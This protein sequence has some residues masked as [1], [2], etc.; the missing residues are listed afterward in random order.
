MDARSCESL[1][2]LKSNWWTTGRFSLVLA[3]LIA[4]AFP[5]VLLGLKT[6]VFRD[7]M[8]FGYS[9][10]HY[11]RESFWAG[12]IPLWNPLSQCGLPFLAQWNTMVLYPLSFIYLLLPCRVAQLLLPGHLFLGGWGCTCW[13]DAGPSR[14]GIGGVG[15]AFAFNG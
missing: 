9:I 1:S 3:L 8:L 14:T 12:E 13:R 2:A 6:F 10:A 5:D 11:H 15:V 7:Y 4:A